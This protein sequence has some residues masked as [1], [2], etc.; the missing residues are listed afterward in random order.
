ML[1]AQLEIRFVRL[2][3]TKLTAA[4]VLRNGC[5]KI[6]GI[7]IAAAVNLI[8]VTN[9]IPIKIN[10]SFTIADANWDA[11]TITDATL[12]VYSNAIV[13]IVAYAIGIDISITIAATNA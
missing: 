8:I 9:T 6:A 13:D 12:I 11:Q 5:V 1:N 7:D 2:T 4:I 3:R 10:E